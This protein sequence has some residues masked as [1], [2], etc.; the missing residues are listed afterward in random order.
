[1]EQHTAAPSSFMEPTT[2]NQ[3]SQLPNA[4]PTQGEWATEAICTHCVCGGGVVVNRDIYIVAPLSRRPLFIGQ[5][6]VW[7]SSLLL[8]LCV[9]GYLVAPVLQP[10]L[11]NKTFRDK[12]DRQLFN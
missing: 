7:P 9:A 4:S 1:M 10:K 12:I 3:H 2:I 6:W 8:F 5:Q 11:M